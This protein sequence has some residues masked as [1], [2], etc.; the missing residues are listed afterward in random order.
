M[1]S[2]NRFV[3]DLAKLFSG[4][5]G[6]AAGLR[7]EMEQRLRQPLERLVA[8]MSLVGREEFEVVRALAEAARN[9]QEALV[10]RVADLE[11]RLARLESSTQSE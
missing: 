1:Q 3:D 5:L 9:E 7:S 2:E 11:A 10:A 4:A 6:A 8:Q